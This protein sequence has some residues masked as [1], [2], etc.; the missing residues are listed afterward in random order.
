MEAVDVLRRVDEPMTLRL[1]DVLGQREL[2][3]DAVDPRRRRSTPRA[4]RAP[5][6]RASTPAGGGRATRCP[7]RSPRVVLPADVDVRRGIVADEDV[8]RQT[9]ASNASTSARPGRG[10]SPQPLF[11]PSESPSS[12]SYP[13][14]AGRVTRSLARAA[15]TGIRKRRIMK[16]AERLRVV[17]VAGCSSSGARNAF[18]RMGRRGLLRGRS[19]ADRRRRPWYACREGL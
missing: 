11:R 16:M 6:S 14:A 10:P 12:A 13:T 9:R 2:D 15:D 4:G 17:V 18:P 8:A 5:R 1:V 7:P 3:E 19:L